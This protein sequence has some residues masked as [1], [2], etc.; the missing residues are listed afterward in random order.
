[1]QNAQTTRSNK[2]SALTVKQMAG[3]LWSEGA[4]PTRQKIEKWEK[5]TYAQQP[6]TQILN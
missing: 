2:C 6:N 4:P 3:R 1:M 5:I